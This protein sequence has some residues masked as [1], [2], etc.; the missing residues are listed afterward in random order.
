[1]LGVEQLAPSRSPKI[2]AEAIKTQYQPGD[3]LLGYQAYSQ[4]LSF[5]TGL[6]F[7]LCQIK[8]ELEFGLQ[9]RPAAA[10]YLPDLR[11]VLPK[12]AQTQAFI[13]LPAAAR[14]Q[15]AAELGRPLRQLAAW[16]KFL[17]VITQ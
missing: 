1:M 10:Y 13:F 16:K 7:Y 6:P 4:G 3:L 15:A 11:S 8:G 14:D 5:Y 2:V 17:V 9:Q 12:L